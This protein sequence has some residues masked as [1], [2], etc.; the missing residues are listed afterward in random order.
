M[1]NSNKINNNLPLYKIDV[2]EIVESLAKRAVDPLNKFSYWI[3]A[4]SLKNKWISPF[5]IDYLIVVERAK[6]LTKK[7]EFLKG[8]VEDKST[9]IKQDKKSQIQTVRTEKEESKTRQ[10][11]NSGKVKKS[12]EHHL[13]R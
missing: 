5:I 12:P 11:L 7:S 3:L 4:Q 1:K 2:V 10:T 9:E 8:S 6:H 13:E